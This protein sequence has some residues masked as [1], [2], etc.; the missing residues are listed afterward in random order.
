MIISIIIIII[1]GVFLSLVD[2]LPGFNQVTDFFRCFFT[3]IGLGMI[4]FGVWHTGLPKLIWVWLWV[5]FRILGLE[6]GLWW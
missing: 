4:V 5:I 2:D 3:L 6:T 1:G